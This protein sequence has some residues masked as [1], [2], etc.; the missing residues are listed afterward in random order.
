MDS[1]L[2]NLSNGPG[3]ALWYGKQASLET[4]LV[5][6]EAKQ[7]DNLGAAEPQVLAYIGLVHSGR[8]EQGKQDTTVYGIAS[9]SSTFV[10]Y[11]ISEGSKWCNK[12][13][14]WG[15]SKAGNLNIIGCLGSIFSEASALR[16]I[17]DGLEK[18]PAPV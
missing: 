8:L 3:Y 13:K 9:D 2:V 12:P 14:I 16:A 6:V 11:R 1:K 17:P 5:I 4:N 18:P 10:F 7:K 15:Q